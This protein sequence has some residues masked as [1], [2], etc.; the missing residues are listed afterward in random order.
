[1]PELNTATDYF[2]WFVLN[3]IVVSPMLIVLY[4]I[5][6]TEKYLKDGKR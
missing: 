6:D 2:L 4:V 1:M 3:V 5:H